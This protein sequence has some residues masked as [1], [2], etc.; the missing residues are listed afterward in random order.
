VS[1]EIN[2]AAHRSV[3]KLSVQAPVCEGSGIAAH[4]IPAGVVTPGRFTTIELISGE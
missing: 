4:G 1:P 3:L 2:A